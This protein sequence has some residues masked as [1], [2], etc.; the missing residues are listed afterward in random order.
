MSISGCDLGIPPPQKTE[1]LRETA[2]SWSGTKLV[3]FRPV[4]SFHSREQG[5]CQMGGPDF[6]PDLKR[7]SI[8]QRMN[9]W[10]NILRKWKTQGNLNVDLVF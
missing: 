9:K 2:D 5:I 1:C 8:D 6:N 3:W 4:V 10:I 7:V